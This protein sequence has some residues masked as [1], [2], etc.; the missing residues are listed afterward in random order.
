MQKCKL[1]SCNRPANIPHEF[2]GRTHGQI[3]CIECG[4]FPKNGKF[5]FCSRTCG[6]KN[7]NKSSARN[8]PTIRNGPSSSG[9]IYFYDRNKP[10]YEF[11]NFAPY[12]V[13]LE[14]E[15]VNYIFPTSEH[16]YQAMKFQDNP[17]LIKQIISDPNPR[18]AFDFA[19]V[20]NKQ[21]LP[22]F[23]EGRIH[24]MTWIL[25]HKFEQ[26]ASL[27]K[28]LLSTGNAKLIEDSPSDSFWGIGNG[29]GENNLGKVLMDIRNRFMNQC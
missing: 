3:A 13:K 17:S 26:H 2:C 16:A 19:H 21:I 5:Q 4:R 12:T 6:L 15:G 28:L 22:H 24:L 29:T 25:Y 18:S 8:M 9:I 10:Y 11:T 7:A 1:E 23:F 27:K 20:H 14:V